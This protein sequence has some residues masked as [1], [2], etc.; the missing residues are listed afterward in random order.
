MKRKSNM[1]YELD[2]RMIVPKSLMLDYLSVRKN[3][4]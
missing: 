4:N 2:N 3:N 1:Y